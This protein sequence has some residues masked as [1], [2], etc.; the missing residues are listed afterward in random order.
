LWRPQP[1]L[2]ETFSATDR[3]LIECYIWQSRSRKNRMGGAICQ[4]YPRC[5]VNNAHFLNLLFTTARP[6]RPGPRRSMVA[7]RD[8]EEAGER[9][10]LSINVSKTGA[11]RESKGIL[12]W[13]R[14]AKSVW[15]FHAAS[16]KNVDRPRLGH[17]D[18]AYTRSM[19]TASAMPV[20]SA[21]SCKSRTADSLQAS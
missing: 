9:E 20:C 2:P 5:S 7:G 4:P 14:L 17:G 8:T 16:R 12:S 6:A 1:L 13:R 21:R 11:T 10:T 3:E 15:Q 19:L 18:H